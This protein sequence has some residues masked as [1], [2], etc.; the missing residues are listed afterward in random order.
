MS[1]LKFTE[2]TKPN[3]DFVSFYGRPKDMMPELVASGFKFGNYRDLG[4]ARNQ[5]YNSDEQDRLLIF[6]NYFTLAG[7]PIL[8]NPKGND[9]ITIVVDLEHKDLAEMKSLVA[10]LNKSTNLNSTYA[11]DLPQEMYD[12]I[13]NISGATHTLKPSLVK[14]LRE[15]AYSN[16]KAREALVEAFFQGNQAE[17]KEYTEL[18]KEHHKTKNIDGVLGFY[19]GNFTGMRLVWAGSVGDY[20]AN[21]YSNDL[22]NSHYGRLFGVGAGGAGAPTT[23]DNRQI[24]TLDELA[25]LK[26]YRTDAPLIKTQKGVY[27]FSDKVQARE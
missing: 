7:N 23:Q 12:A 6:N 10:S 15:N 8:G 1:D 25:V 20:Y 18:V 16:K 24:L 17:A 21:A 14:Q 22:L 9:E 4:R 13:R 2:K 11:L 26:A 27:I 19:P 3:T 5:K